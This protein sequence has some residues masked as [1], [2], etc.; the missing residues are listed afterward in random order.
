M[1][2]F[3]NT[4]AAVRHAERSINSLINFCKQNNGQVYLTSEDGTRIVLNDNVHLSYFVAIN[5]KE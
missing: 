5:I 1:Y 3:G 4:E 2:G